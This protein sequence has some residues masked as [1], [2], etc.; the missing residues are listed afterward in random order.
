LEICLLWGVSRESYSRDHPVHE[1]KYRPDT[2]TAAGTATS[3]DGGPGPGTAAGAG[4]G[5]GTGAGRAAYQQPQQQSHQRQQPVTG[6]DGEYATT[7]PNQG[8]S[9]V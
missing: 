7:D 5:T 4:A 6:H 9:Q 1:E 2:G 8:P 3:T